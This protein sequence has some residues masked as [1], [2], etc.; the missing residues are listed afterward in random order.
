MN[1]HHHELIRPTFSI[2]AVMAPATILRK[3]PKEIAAGDETSCFRYQGDISKRIT[4]MKP[5]SPSSILIP[6]ALALPISVRSCERLGCCLVN[7]YNDH[8]IAG[9]I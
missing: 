3:A 8:H 4:W 7:A 1:S 2:R 5:L 9:Q 6:D